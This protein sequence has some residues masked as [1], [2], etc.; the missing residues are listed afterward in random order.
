[1]NLK[2]LVAQLE[3]DEGLRL[4]PYR[5]TVGKLTI[6]IG[7]NLDDVG[8]TK[9]EAQQLLMNDIKR[10]IAACEKEPWWPSIERDEVR[11]RVMLNMA[12][13]MGLGNSK[14]GLRSFK[15]TLAALERKDYAAVARGMRS[16]MWAKQVG[17]R[18]ERLATMMETG[19]DI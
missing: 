11:M 19:S 4:K 14:K 6:G 17:K 1:M 12:F 3:I 13:N 5:D 7:R 8:I 15:N 18:A 9:D 16:S 10:T 2:K